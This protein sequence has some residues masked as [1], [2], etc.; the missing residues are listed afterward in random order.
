MT[1]I[2]F[3]ILIQRAGNIDGARILFQRLITSIVRLKYKD[4]CEV[5][6]SQGDWGIDV[7]VGNLAE[8]IF[9]WQSKYFIDGIDD[10]QKNQIRDSFKTLMDKSKEKGFKVNYWTLCVPCSL[11]ANERKWWDNWSKKASKEYDVP[12]E[13]KDE[14]ALRSE[15]ETSDAIELREGYFG[16]TPSILNYFIQVINDYDEREIMQLPEKT[17]Y[18][19]AMFIQQLKAANIRELNSAKTQFFNA[20]LISQ[21]VFDKNDTTE[22]NALLSLYEKLRSVWET[23][24]NL[25]LYSSNTDEIKSLYPNTMITIE[26]QDANSLRSPTIKASFVHKQGMMHQLADKCEIGWI[27][28]F[29]ELFKENR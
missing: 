29:R 3:R 27:K 20:E 25:C 12:I 4:A 17:M 9:V 22:C 6:P 26:Q 23:R 5:R 11:S 24:F 14:S 16:S 28:D 7:L 15:L 8:S 18:D 13:L 19:S 10:S 2:D 21:E 1:N